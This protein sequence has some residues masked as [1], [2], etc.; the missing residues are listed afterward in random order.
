MAGVVK[1]NHLIEQISQYDKNVKDTDKD[2][3]QKDQ[4]LLSV[5]SGKNASDEY[6]NDQEAKNIMK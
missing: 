5:L 6:M 1:N 2:Y 3:V 4:S